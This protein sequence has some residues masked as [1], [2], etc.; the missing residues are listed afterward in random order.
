M[1]EDTMSIIEDGAGAG[2]GDTTPPWLMLVVDD[3]DSVHRATRFALGEFRFEDRRLK[4]ISAYSAEQARQIVAEEAETAL[5]L[6]DVVMETET[7]GLEL[8]R[9]IR[10]ELANKSVRI[11]L[12]TGQPGFAPELE[13]IR[14]YDINDYKEKSQL[15]A[16]KLVTTVYS[17]L[18][19]FR[20]IVRLE[21]Q[22]QKLHVALSSAAAAN[23]AKSNFIARMSHEF[24]TPLNGILGLSEMIATET[25]G[26]IG[27][28]KY[29]EYAWDI[30]ASGRRMQE[31]ID[32]VLAYSEG[33]DEKPLKIAPFDLSQLIGELSKRTTGEDT[34]KVKV[35]PDE[36]HLAGSP[37]LMLR[38]DRHAV[39]TMVMNL[40]SNALKH[41]QPKCT[42][43]VTARQTDE[44]GLV[45]S[46]IDN[47][48]GIRPDIVAKLGDP[49][50]ASGDPY[51]TSQGG[52]GL[53]M[54]MA[55]AL[56]ERH[57]GEMQVESVMG[58][59]TTVKLIFPG[60]S[61]VSIQPEQSNSLN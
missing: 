23:R 24:L 48:A 46:V 55:K 61:I 16:S 13:V 12:R 9:W 27:N 49:F 32:G 33:D 47:G 18:R 43:R 58:E 38:A 52:L 29:I 17:A 25:L 35:S 34:L 31:L 7:I 40:V 19:S 41:N 8:V 39:K 14:D 6:L 50:N 11:V 2:N 45:I 42:V 20:D 53:G 30:V 10:N 60:G 5:I 44:G 37:K 51:V 26:P 57:S 1:I 21:D 4:I 36:D 59:G 3:D 28:L 56:I 54:V 15:T 22:S